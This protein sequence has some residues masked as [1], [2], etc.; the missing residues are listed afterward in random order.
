MKTLKAILVLSCLLAVTIITD[1]KPWREYVPQTFYHVFSENQTMWEVCA[2]YAGL[3]EKSR[4]MDEFVYMVKK[5]NGG[6]VIYKPGD[7]MKITVYRVKTKP[8]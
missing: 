7:T 8:E 2:N 5:E 4:T 1:A 3:D 6:K